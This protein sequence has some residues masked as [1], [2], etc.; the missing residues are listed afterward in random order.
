MKCSKGGLWSAPPDHC[1]RRVADAGEGSLACTLAST[2]SHV[3][4]DPSLF[5]SGWQ[6]HIRQV[7]ARLVSYKTTGRCQAG[8]ERDSACRATSALS[9]PSRT[10]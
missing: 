3:P 2:P 7:V 5:V 9:S 1:R 10:S 6:S 8:C 4:S